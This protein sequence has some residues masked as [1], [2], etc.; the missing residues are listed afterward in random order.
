MKIGGALRKLDPMIAA[1]TALGVVS[2]FTVVMT[3]LA[4]TDIWHGEPDVAL[5]WLVVQVGFVIIPAFHVAALVL[6]AKVIR[7]RRLGG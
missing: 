4:L 1:T 5:E 7:L 2:A 6:L 3:W